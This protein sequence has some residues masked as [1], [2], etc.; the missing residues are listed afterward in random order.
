MIPQNLAL[1]S[2]GT[3][4]IITALYHGILGDALLRELEI[5]PSEQTGFVRATYQIGTV[6]WVAGGL[7]LIAAANMRSGFARNWIVGVSAFVYGYPA[8]GNFMLSKG[9]PSFGWIALSTVILLALSGRVDPT[10]TTEEA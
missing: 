7:L 5:H 3:L 1:R 4:A 8:I 6:S 10:Q 9:K 2:S